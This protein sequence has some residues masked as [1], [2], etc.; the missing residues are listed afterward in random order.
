MKQTIRETEKLECKSYT[1]DELIDKRD[2]A[3][4]QI[5]IADRYR[6]SIQ[7]AKSKSSNKHYVY[8]YVATEYKTLLT[9]ID[10]YR[11]RQVGIIADIAKRLSAGEYTGGPNVI[12]INT[13]VFDYEKE[14]PPLQEAIIS[15]V[16][17]YISRRFNP[18]NIKKKSMVFPKD[19]NKL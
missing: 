8:N 2:N 9:A 15:G 4:N 7:K 6:K 1:Y 18:H 19:R 11:K 12:N 17:G 16:K 10:E 3:L 5:M 13:D 14:H